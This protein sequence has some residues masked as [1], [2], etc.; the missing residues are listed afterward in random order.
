MNLTKKDYEIIDDFAKK[1]T[2]VLGSGQI[3]MIT[4]FLD[5]YKKEVK[6]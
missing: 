3:M 6:R 4:L 2:I 5:Y 1:D